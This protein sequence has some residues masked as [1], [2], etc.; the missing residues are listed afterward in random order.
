MP[1]Y[2]IDNMGGMIF[3]VRCEEDGSHTIIS[4]LLV[5][6]DRWEAIDDELWQ[7]LEE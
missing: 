5:E 3:Y 4:N 6:P 1:K 7:I 2:I